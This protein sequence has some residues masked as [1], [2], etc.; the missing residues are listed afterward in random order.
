MQLIQYLMKVEQYVYEFKEVIA[1]KSTQ[2]L[3][4]VNY[5][6]IPGAQHSEKVISF[7]LTMLANI[8]QIDNQIAFLVKD[9]VP[10]YVSRF[11]FIFKN[12]GSQY[13]NPQKLLQSIL[14]LLK[15]LSFI[16]RKN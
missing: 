6:Q 11:K 7:S 8:M 16:D 12:A 1:T 13:K 4:G 14:K 5:H 3:Q 15:S 10:D 9:Y 2:I